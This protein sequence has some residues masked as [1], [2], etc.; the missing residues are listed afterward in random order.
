MLIE[1]KGSPIYHVG[2]VVRVVDEPYTK[3]VFSWAHGM[4]K[5]CGKTAKISSVEWSGCY[6]TYRYKIDITPTYVFCKDCFTPL[7][8]ESDSAFD[9]SCVDAILM[10]VA[11]A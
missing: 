11:G 3:C 10:E 2:D 7:V 6:E 1:T 4:C 5:Y 9:V 8:D